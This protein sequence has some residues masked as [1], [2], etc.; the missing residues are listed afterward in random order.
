M[1][2]NQNYKAMLRTELAQKA[3]V[4][5]RTFSRWIEREMPSIKDLGYQERDK[6]LPP[7]IVKFLC[8]KYVIILD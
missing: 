7:S 3:G 8:E 4:S 5:L 2:E 6:F 1:K